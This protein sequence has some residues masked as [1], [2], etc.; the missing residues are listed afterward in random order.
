MFS[1]VPWR[2][3]T[4]SPLQTTAVPRSCSRVTLDTCQQRKIQMMCFLSAFGA[5]KRS[6]FRH[7]RS[8]HATPTA[9]RDAA[10]EARPTALLM[11]GDG[12]GAREF[13]AAWKAVSHHQHLATLAVKSEGSGQVAWEL[14]IYTVYIGV[15]AAEEQLRRPDWQKFF[16]ESDAEAVPVV[17][18]GIGAHRRLGA[19]PET[20]MARVAVRCALRHWRVALMP[21]ERV[22]RPESD[23]EVNM[24]VDFVELVKHLRQQGAEEILTVLLE[25]PAFRCPESVALA[26]DFE[27]EGAAVFLGRGGMVWLSTS[28]D[29]SH[30]GITLCFRGRS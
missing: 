1:L 8:G 21:S 30:L 23:V 20:A 22:G 24:D 15:F 10:G 3:I 29:A 2:A 4:D 25:G 18:H 7:L 28:F 13:R 26:A 16:Q 12:Q 5:C 27:R 11:D 19:L 9:R 17:P 14:L 6:R